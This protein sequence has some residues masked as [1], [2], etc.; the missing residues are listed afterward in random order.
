MKLEQN[1]HER[2]NSSVVLPKDEEANV[3]TQCA[4]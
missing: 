4:E 3:L 1:T 2:Q